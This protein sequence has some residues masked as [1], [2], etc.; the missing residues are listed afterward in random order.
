MNSFRLELSIPGRRLNYCG[1]SRPP[2]EEDPD[3]VLNLMDRSEGTAAFKNMLGVKKELVLDAF[4][5]SVTGNIAGFYLSEKFLAG[6]IKEL[7][8]IIK[9]FNIDPF[10]E[11]GGDKPT[12][13]RDSK[14]DFRI[15]YTLMRTD[16][17]KQTDGGNKDFPDKFFA[18]NYPAR[19]LA[20]MILSGI[21]DICTA[22]L[23]GI[24]F[25]LYVKGRNFARRASELFCLAEKENGCV[26]AELALCVGRY[27]RK[28]IREEAL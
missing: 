3:L 12:V 4:R 14:D 23:G 8:G 24:E 16:P 21:Y 27:V 20:S 28:S 10:S 26:P 13:S 25:D 5:I 19:I 11:T 18:D 6:R 7:S 9:K 22:E 1:D 2:A 15:F 17:A